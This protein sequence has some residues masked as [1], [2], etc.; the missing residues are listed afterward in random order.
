MP[1][2]W[3]TLAVHSPRLT[4]SPCYNGHDK[5][6][7][8]SS[9][10]CFSLCL[11]TAACPDSFCEKTL[12]LSPLESRP[13]PPQ[14]VPQQCLGSFMCVLLRASGQLVA[15]Q[16]AAGPHCW[17]HALGPLHTVTTRK[18]VKGF[19]SI[20]TNV[21]TTGTGLWGHFLP[22]PLCRPSLLLIRKFIPDARTFW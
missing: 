10:S 5:A 16:V 6:A 22:H 14:T 21:L 9:L 17:V 3:C 8:F 2:L 4:V 19:L 12:R 7:A 11:F 1:L 13:L 15:A 18:D 20:Q